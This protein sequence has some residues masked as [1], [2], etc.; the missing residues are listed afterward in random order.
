MPPQVG[1]KALAGQLLLDGEPL[2]PAPPLAILLHKPIGYVVTSPEDENVTDP[3][4]Y[5]L[6]PYRWAGGH[7][8]VLQE[9]VQRLVF[10]TLCGAVAAVLLG[11]H[12]CACRL[13]QLGS[14]AA[15]QPATFQA[16]SALPLTCR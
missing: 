16:G 13:G 5:D 8:G 4:I 12:M 2:D 15:L 10:A 6:L 11:V 7:V 3:K 1:E 9:L 14:L